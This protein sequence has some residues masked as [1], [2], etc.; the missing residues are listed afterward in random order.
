MRYAESLGESGHWYDCVE[1]CVDPIGENPKTHGTTFTA[2]L[3]RLV[4]TAVVYVVRVARNA[5]DLPAAEHNIVK[6]RSLSRT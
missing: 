4:P 3:L 1:G 6:A 2:L 5:K